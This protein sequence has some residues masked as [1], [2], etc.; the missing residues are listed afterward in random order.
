MKILPTSLVRRLEDNHICIINK[1]DFDKKLY[2]IVDAV[3]EVVVEEEEE[4]VIVEEE[5]V[6]EEVDEV[7]DL[8][9]MS[10]ADAITFIE[11]NEWTLEELEELDDDRKTVQKAIAGMKED[12]E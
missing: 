10:A 1:S 7:I 12:L 6:E 2:V 11:E 3:E 4:E 9:I 5:V 8:S